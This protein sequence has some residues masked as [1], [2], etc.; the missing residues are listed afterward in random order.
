MRRTAAL[1]LLS[2]IA[3]GAS[4]SEDAPET[5]QPASVVHDCTTRAGRFI[6]AT[7]RGACRVDSF[8]GLLS[9]RDG[10]IECR[11]SNPQLRI[12]TIAADLGFVY[13]DTD[14]DRTLNGRCELR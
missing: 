1:A 13:E 11:I 10:A 3:A 14:S 12:V 9:E 8:E 5:G 4:F 7:Q 2:S 6:V